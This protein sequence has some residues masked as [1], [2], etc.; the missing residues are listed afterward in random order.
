MMKIRTREHN[1]NDWK[2][3]E[4]HKSIRREISTLVGD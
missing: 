1:S 3:H 2:L 4:L